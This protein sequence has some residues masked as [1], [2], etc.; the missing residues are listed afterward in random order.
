MA[1]DTSHMFLSR[2]NGRNISYDKL[3]YN[4]QTLEGR[5]EFCKQL[6]SKNDE[7]LQVYFDEYYLANA[8]KWD[9]L[10]H[11][12]N[13]CKKLE[14]IATYILSQVPDKAKLE[15]R[16][17]NGEKNFDNVLRREYSLDRIIED[18][19]KS[20]QNQTDGD[21]IHFLKREENSWYLPKTIKIEKKDL[22]RQDELGEKLRQYET[23]KQMLINK[24]NELS[25][26]K[27]VD[28]KVTKWN[29]TKLKYMIGAIDND[30]VDLKV[31]CIKPI[32]FNDTLKGSTKSCWNDVD[33]LNPVHVEC[34]LKL[35]VSSHNFDDDLSMLLNYFNEI[36]MKV[37]PELSYREK[38]VLRVIRWGIKT[39]EKINET[40]LIG[41]NHGQVKEQIVIDKEELNLIISHIVTSFINKYHKD[42]QCYLNSRR[43]QSILFDIVPTKVC[44]CCGKRKTLNSFVK[45]KDMKDGHR[46]KCKQC[47]RKGR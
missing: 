30:M 35:N 22:K 41:Y 34:F 13:I 23:F 15:Y 40:L 28:G 36:L 19:S 10:S 6:L 24:K 17:Y 27:V 25:K 9:Y 38:E 14:S 18:A 21:V 2:I 47:M 33:F 26:L 5:L 4:I 1:L 16:F 3:N 11:E 43:D 29:T 46:N 8:T 12:N 20:V 37:M 42:V 39:V 44:K 31:Q 32:V 45:K 7:F